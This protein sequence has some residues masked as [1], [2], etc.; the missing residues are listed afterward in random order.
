MKPMRRL[1]LVMSV[2]LVLPPS[3]AM[4]QSER[5]S[6]AP[7]IYVFGDS[8]SDVG[9]FTAAL[10]QNPVPWDPDRFS[11]GRLWVDFV[12][13][14]YHTRIEASS[15]GGTN[16]AVA[17][18]TIDPASTFLPNSSGID[19]ALMY[20][21]KGPDPFAVHMVFIGTNDLVPILAG[22]SA[23]QV[24]SAA[25]AQ[26]ESML[27]LLVNNGVKHL[28]VA[29]LPD[30]GDAPLWSMFGLGPLAD[31]ARRAVTIL[32][33]EIRRIVNALDVCDARVID[34]A[35]VQE[36]IM[37]NPHHFGF[38]NVTD[39]CWANDGSVC[40]DPNTYYWFQASHPS[41]RAHFAWS[42]AFTREARDFARRCEAPG[43]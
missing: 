15:Q 16:Y 10:G 31:V 9:N 30:L 39:A 18:A 19:Q 20:I 5:R 1:I 13:K 32:N 26:L 24:A 11:N 34:L 7:T 29:T 38:E 25:S 40:S 14:A 6:S 4:A 37:A 23:E 8:V 43:R 35:Q 41:E 27:A 12:A 3:D 2:T 17:G 28:W 36:E 22:A 21:A 33:V 42:L